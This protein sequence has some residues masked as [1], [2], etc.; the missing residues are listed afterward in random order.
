MMSELLLIL[1]WM[2][3]SMEGGASKWNTMYLLGGGREEEKR[4]GR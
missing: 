2:R 1:F 3:S 4:G